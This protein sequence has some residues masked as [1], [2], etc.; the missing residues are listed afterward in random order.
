MIKIKRETRGK[1]V[2][3][4]VAEKPST[5]TPADSDVVMTAQEIAE[6]LRLNVG[7]IYRYLREGKIK[8]FGFGRDRRVLRADVLALFK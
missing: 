1:S 2:V 4:P 7:T 3:V 8:S 6:M 5:S